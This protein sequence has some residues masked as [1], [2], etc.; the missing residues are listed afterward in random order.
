MQAR[1]G[2]LLSAGAVTLFSGLLLLSSSFIAFS[3][4]E[5][6]MDVAK[7]NSEAYADGG[8]LDSGTARDYDPK[9]VH[10]VDVT[11]DGR[12]LLRLDPSRG[13]LEISRT[14]G[15]PAGDKT[16]LKVGVAP[17]TVRAASND[18]AWVID[19]IADS[20]SIV[21]LNK[22]VVTGTLATAAEPTD[23]TFSDSPP[24][25]YVAVAHGISIVPH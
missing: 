25:A 18:E 8:S 9:P 15:S 10:P 16:V 22:G 23:V 2:T 11:P 5:P 19:N 21:D 1:T 13:T 20:I 12:H 6:P 14:H 24:R 3:H 4:S 7:L 17:V